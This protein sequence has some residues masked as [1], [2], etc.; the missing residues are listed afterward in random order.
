M[1]R[2]A[3]PCRKG[4]T[5]AVSG[6]CESESEDERVSVNARPSGKFGLR[7]STPTSAHR[8][9]GT[10]SDRTAARQSEYNTCVL[11]DEDQEKPDED[12]ELPRWYRRARS[13]STSRY[14][15]SDSIAARFEGFDDLDER[16]STFT[17]L[18]A[19][20]SMTNEAC[21]DFDD[22]FSSECRATRRSRGTIDDILTPSV[23]LPT[24][25]DSLGPTLD[26]FQKDSAFTF[27]AK[28]A[29][30]EYYG[31]VRLRRAPQ[32]SPCRIA[33]P[34]QSKT[35]RNRRYGGRRLANGCIRFVTRV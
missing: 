13:L 35:Y 21:A 28:S 34:T 12:S 31:N 16:D 33:A 15:H 25:I 7:A 14:G 9:I 23:F 19:P 27:S 32:A 29:Q 4:H 3:G 2:A 20:A 17:A 26:Q 6:T 8:A 22:L 1:L 18:T 5:L 11:P 30:S 24:K 10:F